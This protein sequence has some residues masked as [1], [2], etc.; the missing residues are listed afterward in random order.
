MRTIKEYKEFVLDNYTFIKATKYKNARDTIM[1]PYCSHNEIYITNSDGKPHPP[2]LVDK[3][4]EHIQ[5][6][7][8]DKIKPE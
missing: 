5:D 1:C 7:H 8:S 3:F 4:V 2:L 6:S